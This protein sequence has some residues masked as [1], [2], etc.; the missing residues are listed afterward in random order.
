MHYSYYGGTCVDCF[1]SRAEG[2]NKES[3][4]ADVYCF[5]SS[6]SDTKVCVDPAVGCHTR[7]KTADADKVE[8][9]GCGACPVDS[10][11]TCTP[12]TDLA[13][14]NT[15]GKYFGCNEPAWMC[16]TDSG[17]LSGAATFVLT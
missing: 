1:T 10:A 16:F 3:G 6:D 11:Y 12:C 14:K 7:Y 5:Q 9:R 2:C 8:E 13:D 4:P 15:D 17:D